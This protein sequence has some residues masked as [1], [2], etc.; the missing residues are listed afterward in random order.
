MKKSNTDL[1]SRRQTDARAET[2]QRGNALL[3]VIGLVGILA[4]LGVSYLAT[5]QSQSRMLDALSARI[6]GQNSA[7]AVA[8]LGV[9]RVISDW[10]ANPETLE[11]ATWIC[12]HDG[13]DVTLVVENESRRL[14]IN[15][16]DEAALAR[17]IS[18]AGVA[19]GKAPAIASAIA[20]YVDRDTETSGG[21]AETAGPGAG[22]VTSPMKNAPLEI[23]E[24]LRLIPGIG[25]AEYQRLESALSLYSTRTDRLQDSRA[26]ADA[27]ALPARGVYRITVV[28]T[29]IGAEAPA[30]NRTVVVELDPAEPL[31]PSVRVWSTSAAQ[32]AVRQGRAA[33]ASQC[34]DLLLGR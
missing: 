12:R 8:N 5:T 26:S 7:D 20:D 19:P 11:S 3:V 18:L 14:N 1:R 17:E 23:I 13:A 4:A 27:D 33:S 34:R 15:F 10:R 16:A 9:W 2:G 21:L 30:F 31:S 32:S 22:G 24:E 28:V 25:G 6:A 29:P